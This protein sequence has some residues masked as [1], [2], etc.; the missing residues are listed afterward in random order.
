M[1]SKSQAAVQLLGLTKTYGN[2]TVVNSLD[3]TIPRGTTFGLIGPNGA[4]KS[5]TLKMMMGMSNIMYE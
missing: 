1:K 5:T 4:G 2:T 3:L